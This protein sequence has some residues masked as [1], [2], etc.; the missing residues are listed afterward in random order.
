MADRVSGM[1]LAPFWP[2]GA[3]TAPPPVEPAPETLDLTPPRTDAPTV[4]EALAVLQKEARDT[5]ALQ[6]RKATAP[7]LIVIASYV[8]LTV[9]LNHVAA[10]QENPAD[11]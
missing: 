9:I 11:G 6:P 1:F 7:P 8:E 4:A 2:P 10:L 5:V 3:I